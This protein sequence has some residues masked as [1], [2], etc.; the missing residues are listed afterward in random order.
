MGKRLYLIRH[1]QDDETYLG[2]WSQNPLTTAGKIHIQ[3]IAG[4]LAFQ[5]NIK[6][7]FSSDLLRAKQTAEI[8]SE[9][10]LLPITFMEQFRETNNGDLADLTFEAFQEQF[11]GFYWRS[12]AEDQAYPNGE[13]PATFFQRVKSAWFE[14]KKVAP[15]QSLLVT[16]GGVI[17]AILCLE[18]N[19]PFTNKRVD[20]PVSHG[21][22]VALEV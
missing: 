22:M 19:R 20:Y 7:L 2:G 1:G 14:F 4:Q 21:Q 9:S 15:D 12:L 11:P 5:E 18:N 17:N 3:E 6:H 13:S 8:L 16:H 10:L